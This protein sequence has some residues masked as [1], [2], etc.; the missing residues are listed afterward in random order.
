L[1]KSSSLLILFFTWDGSNRVG[2][3]IE[4]IF[5]ICRSYPLLGPTSEGAHY[6]ATFM[7]LCIITRCFFIR[8]STLLSG[9]RW[10]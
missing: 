9:I 7:G 1:C 10:N 3:M 5:G 6:N 4:S 2:G 8:R